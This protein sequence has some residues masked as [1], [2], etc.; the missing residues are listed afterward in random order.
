MT[1]LEILLTMSPSCSNHSVSIA[2]KLSVSQQ[3]RHFCLYPTPPQKNSVV[4][5]GLV[6]LNHRGVSQPRHLSTQVNS[7]IPQAELMQRPVP[8]G[9]KKSRDALI[10]VFNWW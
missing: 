2:W 7:W 8:W 5:K 10:D 6:Q 3:G 4:A 9:R 1:I